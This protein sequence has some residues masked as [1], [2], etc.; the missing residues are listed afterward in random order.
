[1]IFHSV[2]AKNKYTQMAQD[3]SQEITLIVAGCV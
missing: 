3:F 1:M 2:I